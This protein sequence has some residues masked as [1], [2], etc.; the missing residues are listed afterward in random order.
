MKSQLLA[1]PALQLRKN[2]TPR[3]LASLTQELQR[4]KKLGLVVYTDL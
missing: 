4:K 2:M 1:F 3:M